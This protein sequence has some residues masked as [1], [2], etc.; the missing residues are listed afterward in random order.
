M[1]TVAKMILNDWIRGK[2]PFYTLPESNLNENEGIDLNGLKET[3]M[4]KEQNQIEVFLLNLTLND[5]V[6]T[7]RASSSTPTIEEYQSDC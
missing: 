5:V 6:A 1:N 7:T 4:E 2:I 3:E